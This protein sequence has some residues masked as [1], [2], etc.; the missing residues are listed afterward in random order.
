MKKKFEFDSKSYKI[1]RITLQ[2]LIITL[3]IIG[4]I[5]LTIKLFPYF[6]RVKQDEEYKNY[7]VNK[8]RN[9]GNFSSFIIIIL[10]IIQT[11]FMI[12]PGGPIVMIAGILL[13][14]GSAVLTSIIGQ[15]LGGVIVFILVRFFGFRFISLFVNP[16]KILESKILKN[17]ARCEV[18]IAGYLMI[19]ALPKDIV[20]FIAPFTGI[21]LND[22]VMLSLIARIPMTVVSVFIGSSLMNSNIILL[23]ILIILSCTLALICFIFHEKIENLLQKDDNIYYIF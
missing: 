17:K 16:K 23:I 3:L 11:I 10:Q 2:I 13:E 21:K 9:Y 14:P 5:Y 19:P 4:A 8:I 20:S 18:M 12:I 22:F 7:I 1:I 15:T 6:I